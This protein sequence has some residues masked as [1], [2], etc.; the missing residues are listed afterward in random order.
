MIGKRNIRRGSC[1][2]LFGTRSPRDVLDEFIERV[3][4]ERFGSGRESAPVDF[5]SCTLPMTSFHFPHSERKTHPRFNLARTSSVQY[6][7]HCLHGTF[8]VSDGTVTASPN[9]EVLPHESLRTS[10][11]GEC[12]RG[13]HPTY[14]SANSQLQHLEKAHGTSRGVASQDSNSTSFPLAAEINGPPPFPAPYKPCIL[15]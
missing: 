11:R 3:L 9:P 8:P 1:R 15:C 10:N 7:F 2:C 6:S 4:V 5:R 12:F 13:Q 14:A